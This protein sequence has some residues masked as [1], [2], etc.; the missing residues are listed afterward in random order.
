MVSFLAVLGLITSVAAHGHVTSIVVDGIFYEGYDPSYQYDTPAPITVGW[1][2]PSVLDNGFVAP[3][4]YA[5]ADIICH[6]SATNAMIAAP[7]KGGSKIELL[8]TPWPTSHKGPIIDYLANCNGPCETVDKT[9]LKWFKIDELALLDP[10]PQYGT[11][12]TDVMIANNN[13]WTVVIPPTIAPGNYVLRHEIIALHAASQANGA[14]NY[15][16]CVNLAISSTGTDKPA[17]VLGTTFYS[18]KDPGV[19]FNIDVAPPIPA[20]TIPGPPLYSAAVTVSQVKMPKPTASASGVAA[21]ANRGVEMK[22]EV[23]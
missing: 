19:M 6:R 7:A 2:T 18:A 17:G 21:L 14:Q 12:S 1:K 4:A 13:T 8:W 3:A 5:N 10:K 11:W 9:K 22:W 23:V 20:Y 16:F 15:P